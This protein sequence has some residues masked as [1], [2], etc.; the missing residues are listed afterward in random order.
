MR[1]RR[2]L[3]TNTFQPKLIPLLLT[4]RDS[5]RIREYLFQ[6]D[7]AIGKSIA[8]LMVDENDI[9]SQTSVYATDTL[10]AGTFGNFF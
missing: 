7:D 2:S 8:A 6:F 1:A 3:I 4:T 10:C 9:H 5:E